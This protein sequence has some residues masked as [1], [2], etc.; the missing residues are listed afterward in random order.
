MAMT[1]Y[2][3]TIRSTWFDSHFRRGYDLPGETAQ[4]IFNTM[5]SNWCKHFSISPALKDLLNSHAHRNESQLSQS[6]SKMNRWTQATYLQNFSKILTNLYVHIKKQFAYSTFL[7]P[8]SVKGGRN[9]AGDLC[10][11]PAFS[12]FV[13]YT[14]SLVQRSCLRGSQLNDLSICYSQQDEVPLSNSFLFVLGQN[15]GQLGF[16]SD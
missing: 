8:S 9:A 2:I 13:L 15:I 11:S 5:T 3:F 7:F 14:D 10:H 16:W 1:R 6:W 12:L 4:A